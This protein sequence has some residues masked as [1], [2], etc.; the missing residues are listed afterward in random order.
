MIGIKLL[1]NGEPIGIGGGLGTVLVA[2]S[3][4]TVVPPDPQYRSSSSEGSLAYVA[5]GG[6]IEENGEDKYVNWVPITALTVGD[7]VQFIVVETVKISSARYPS[8]ERKFA[9]AALDHGSF[10]LNRDFLNISVR[11]NDG[12]EYLAGG[13]GCRSAEFLLS[14]ESKKGTITRLSASLSGS[15]RVKMNAPIWLNY[16]DLRVGDYF[17]VKLSLNANPSVPIRVVEGLLEP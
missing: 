3:F 1:L 14:G 6:I 9:Y 13:V 11:K 5:M 17:T 7:I 2:A 16:E 12:E 10:D 8:A 4:T 15:D